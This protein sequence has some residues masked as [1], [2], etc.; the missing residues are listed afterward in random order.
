M[1]WPPKKSVS[2]QLFHPLFEEKGVEVFMLRDDLLHPG[3]S[4]NKWRKLKYNLL[5]VAEVGIKTVVT[6]GG[7]HSNHI[8]AV[9]E[10]G[11]VFGFQT[12]GLI[13][14]YEAYRSNT[15]LKKAAELGMEIRF[16]SK[17][18]FNRIESDYLPKLKMELG[19]FSYVP[20][21]GGNVLG[22]KGCVEINEDIH[23]ETTHILTACGTGSTMAGIVAG[24]KQSQCVLGFPAMK[25]GGFM[26]A[27]VSQFLKEFGKVVKADFEIITAYDFGGF[28]KLNPGLV[29]FINEF[30]R[31]HDISLDAVYNGKMMFGLFDLLKKDYFK[32]GSVISAIHTGGV[33]GNLGL[34]EKKGVVLPL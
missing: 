24:A 4:G 9:A 27:D 15:T 7:S 8:A 32:K 14:G 23:P 3:I 10:A 29:D 20:M 2:Q 18:E 21:G 31:D 25:N 6:V 1:N 30:K 28:A 33:Q 22:M 12:I 34:M 19:A 26:Q 16:F 11:K 13:R 5:S 17:E